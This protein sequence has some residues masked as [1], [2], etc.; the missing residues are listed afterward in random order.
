M[1]APSLNLAQFKKTKRDFDN[2]AIEEAMKKA[3]Q[4]RMQPGIMHDVKITG[5]RE[6]SMKM[7]ETNPTWMQWAWTFENSAG[8]SAMMTFLAPLGQSMDFI[9]RTTG[10]STIFP[11]ASFG[12]MLTAL[13]LS[14]HRI[15][16]L[17]RIVETNGSVL[18][19]AVG[20]QCRMIL[21]WNKKKCH[22]I[23]DNDKQA[24]FLADYQDLLITEQ[25]FAVPA[26]DE[27][28]NSNERWAE[29]AQYCA[30]EGLQFEVGPSPEILI[31]DAIVNPL[32]QIGIGKRRPSATAAGRASNRPGTKSPLLR[33][34][35]KPK[36]PPPP[37]KPVEEADE[38]EDDDT[39]YDPGEYDE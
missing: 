21:K 20:F 12:K 32:E 22:P 28:E 7:H 13:G 2:D 33:E 15:E 23:Y 9:A 24:W 27:V 38:I 14:E 39:D 11:L 1:T 29:M 34:K 37:P 36:A 31:N 8:E 4:R 26:A 10:K 16:F 3:S 17:D 18:S 19:D 25:P 5:V 6:G 30:D 35:L